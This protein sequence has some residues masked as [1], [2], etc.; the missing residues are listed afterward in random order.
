MKDARN[1]TARRCSA[2]VG[3]RIRKAG[4]VVLAF[5]ATVCHEPTGPSQRV[6]SVNVSLDSALV[7]V[8]D[9][10]LGHAVARDAQGG[11]VASATIT[12]SSRDTRVAKVSPAGWVTAINGGRTSIIADAGGARGTLIII[13]LRPGVTPLSSRLPTFVFIQQRHQLVPFSRDP[14]RAAAGAL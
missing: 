8:S 4:V 10:L 13:V 5:L 3:S 7:Y 12:W 11:A 1:D 14:A 9:S 2:A 6:T